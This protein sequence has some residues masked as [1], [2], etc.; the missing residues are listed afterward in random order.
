MA[1]C[2]IRED[3]T[4]KAG[5]RRIARE[6]LAKAIRQV[7]AIEAGS[8]PTDEA[9]HELRKCC[10]KL[11][12][13]YR[14]VRP[15][16]PD[17]RHENAAIRDAAARLSSVRDANVLVDTLD[18]L[19]RSGGTAPGGV[20][21]VRGRLVARRD[22]L[23]RSEDSAATL[24]DFRADLVSARKRAKRW[25]LKAD[26]FDAVAGGLEKSFAGAR[27]A[28]KLARNDRDPEAFHEWRKRTKDHWYHARLLGQIWPEVLH[29]HAGVVEE[30]GELLGLHHDL[31]I[32]REK[33]PEVAEGEEEA[34][35]YLDAIAKRRETEIADECVALGARVFAEKPAALSRRWRAYWKR[36]TSEG[37]SPDA[38]G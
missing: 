19:L 22:E 15:A 14:L 35:T 10:K 37:H 4:A 5:F 20:E 23:A 29:T 31:S 1:Y 28:M 21:A 33:L 12:G 13:L 38:A 7:D 30:L 24:K 11:R 9:I 26:G 6:L 18:A 36:W 17:Y 34:R 3:S 25:K 16:F 32:F 27:A 8:S 2:F